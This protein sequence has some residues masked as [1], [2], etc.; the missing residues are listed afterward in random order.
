MRRFAASDIEICDFT[1]VGFDELA[2]RL[3]CVAHE[4]REDLVSG[5]GVVDSDDLQRAPLR[6]HGRVEELVGVHLAEALEALERHPVATDLED[7]RAQLLEGERVTV[8]LAQHDVEGREPGQ[9]VELLVDLHEAP[10]LG[11]LEQRT[12]ELVGL[13]RAGLALDQHRDDLPLVVRDERG[14]VR[15]ACGVAALEQLDHGLGV[16]RALVEERR[17]LQELDRVVAPLRAQRRGPALVLLEQPAVLLPARVGQAERLAVAVGDL[18]LLELVA[19]QDL[20]ELGLL[21]DVDVLLAGLDLV[22]RRLRDVDVAGLDQLGHL[23]VEEGQHERP[24]VGPVHVGVGHDDDLV[25]AGL[26]DVELLADPG[27]DRGDQRLDLLVREHLVDAVLLDVDDLAAQRQDRLGVAIAPLLGRAAG[28]VA[29]DDEDLGERGIAHRAVGQLAGQRR[30]LERRLAPGEVARLAGGVAGAGCVYGLADHHA[31]LRRVLLEEL[32]EPLVDGGLD[33]ALHRRV[34]ELGL[35]LPLELRLADLDRD[36]RGQALADVLALQVGI[37]LLELA[38]LARVLVDRAGQRRAEAGQVRAALVRVD[39]VGEREQRLLVGVVPLQGDLDL[40]DLLR[41]LD[42][43]DGR[44]QRLARALAVQ[45]ADEVDDAALVL[46]AR[47]E[48][49]AALVA[50]VDLQALREERHLAEALLEDGAVVLDRLE[51]LEV[52]QERDARAA[53]VRLTPL[54]ELRRGGPALV[55]LGVLAAVAP[56]GQVQ[57]LRQRVDDRHADSVETAGDLVAPALAELAPGV[58]DGQHD[59]GRGTLLLLHR[60]DGDASAVVGDG[61][62]VVRVDHDLDVVRFAGERLVDSVVDNLVDQV[63]QPAGAGGTDVHARTLANGLEPLEDR[64]VL[65][66]VAPVLMLLAL[67][68]LLWGVAAVLSLVCQ[69]FPSVVARSSARTPAHREKPRLRASLR[70]DRGAT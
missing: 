2:A 46:E 52:R 60:V 16:V 20:F 28:G 31:R 62:R 40:A 65:G 11:R 43:D 26:L 66:A 36:D 58:Q 14:L 7:R 44:M 1:C 45:V 23:P 22:E 35:R 6:V 55:G 70:T 61:H 59:L 13:G 69:A 25:V 5:A 49:L 18:H 48:A 63:V 32:G 17:L 9:R 64:D 53:A 29:L 38:D 67:G 3:D 51:D 68:A 39:V 10:V 41:V 24:D 50:E 57:P 4:H 27:A 37:L 56:D 15:L 30:V 54:R 12:R 42:V 33:E 34:A 8:L 21:L 19:Q 47:L